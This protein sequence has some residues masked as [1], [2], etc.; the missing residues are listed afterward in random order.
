MEGE[1]DDADTLCDQ[2]MDYGFDVGRSDFDSLDLHLISCN[3]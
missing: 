2:V 1:P 3:Q